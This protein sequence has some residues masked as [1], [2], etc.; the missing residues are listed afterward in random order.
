MDNNI[1]KK[2]QSSLI[3]DSS[4]ESA[5]KY[6]SENI[7]ARRKIEDDFFQ[8]SIDYREY[9]FSPE[10]YEGVM[11]ALYIAI[12]PYLAGLGFLFLFIAKASYEYFLDF[13]LTSYLIIW[14]IGY[15]VCAVTLL[16]IIFL[17]WL[18]HISNRV[19]REK[20]RKKPLR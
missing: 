1:E 15:E 5:K 9:V 12:I 20:A 10:G 6:Q 4:R 16:V 13:N 11:M 17:A 3:T 18:K 14:A 8:Q 2:Y 7:K 19:E